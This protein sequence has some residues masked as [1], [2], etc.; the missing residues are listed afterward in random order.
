[1]STKKYL[2]ELQE[3]ILHF[4]HLKPDSL[5]IITGDFNQRTNPMPLLTNVSG[6][7]ASRKGAKLDWTFSNMNLLRLQ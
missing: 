2:M 6:I 4:Q 7:K 1:M 3:T 5:W